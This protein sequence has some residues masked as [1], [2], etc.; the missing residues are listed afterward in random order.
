MEYAEGY[1]VAQRSGTATTLTVDTEHLSD[2]TLRRA[3]HGR[4]SG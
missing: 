2:F 1:P 3:D 4:R